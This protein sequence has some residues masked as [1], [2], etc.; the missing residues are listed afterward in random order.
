[1]SSKIKVD[2][3]ENVAGSGN[4]SLG[5]GHNLVVPGNNTTSGNA[6]VGGTLGVT[7]TSALTGVVTIDGSNALSTASGANAKLNVGSLSGT[8]G[9]LN[10][11]VAGTD[12]AGAYRLINATD[13]VS[14]NFVVRTDNS[15]SENIVI[16]GPETA[17]AITFKIQG[18]ERMRI[19]TAGY[20]TKYTPAFY[21]YRNS[22]NYTSSVDIVWNTVVYNQGSHYDVSNG[23]F[24]A[25]VT[26][27]YQFNVMSSITGGAG[28]GSQNRLHI[29]GTAQAAIWPIFNGNENHTSHANSFLISLN[30]SD[31][32]TIKSASSPTTWYGGVNSHNYFSGFL[33][34]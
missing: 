16:L 24:T 33:V 10:V 8:P 22:G 27:V 30:A 32:V 21:A 1:M 4:V 12:G 28:N 17:S 6:T 20:T 26:G 5:S 25:P 29:N 13:G 31:Y 19:H 14:T 9:A 34:G 15:A 18:N 11:N 7:G 2:T 3:I 23:R